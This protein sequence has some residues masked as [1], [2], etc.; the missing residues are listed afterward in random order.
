[1]L[2]R[3]TGT[4]RVYPETRDAAGRHLGLVEPG[5]VRPFEAAPD[6]MWTPA[7]SEEAAPEPEAEPAAPEPAPDGPQPAAP[8]VIPGA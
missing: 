3:F 2:Y 7:D 5:D 4:E 6:G 8:A 1:V